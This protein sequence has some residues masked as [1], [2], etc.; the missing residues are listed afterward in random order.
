MEEGNTHFGFWE[1]QV[2]PVVNPSDGSEIRLMAIFR[3]NV[4]AI[5][6]N[7][8]GDIFVGERDDIS[9]AW[10][11]PQGGIDPGEAPDEALL[12][13]IEEEIGLV[14]EHLEILESKGGYRYQFPNG[15]VKW[16]KYRGQ[17]QTYF[18]CRFLGE[19]AHINIRTKH[20]E[21]SDWKW[22]RPEEF[23]LNWVPDFKREVYQQVMRD[24]FEV[25]I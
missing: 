11:F 10:Q 24:F 17:E 20:P 15:V 22:I 4:A 8:C 16:K 18:R 6:E 12:R 7:S 1:T 25:K 23:N 2:I 9:G 5:L 3:L 19:D 14:S 21:F 13:E